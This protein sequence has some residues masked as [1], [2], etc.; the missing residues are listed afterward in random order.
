MANKDA[1]INAD[2]DTPKKVMALI[3]C[4]GQEIKSSMTRQLKETGLSLIQLDIL[5]ALSFAPNKSLTVNQIKANMIDDSPNVSR[6]V[7][8]LMDAGYIEKRRN[9]DDQRMVHITI[10]A[11][12]EQAH[13]DADKALMAL[14]SPL[15][16]K[17]AEQLLVLLKKL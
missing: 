9:R 7:N 4:L 13:I 16:D 14:K 8:K 12:G 17:D 1:I 2:I 6:A 5:H 3:A 15:N 11:A 10:T